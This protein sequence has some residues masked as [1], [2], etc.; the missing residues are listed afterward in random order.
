MFKQI[1]QIY[2][3]FC[4]YSFI[5]KIDAFNAQAQKSQWCFWVLFYDFA[6]NS[7]NVHL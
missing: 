6:S 2:L 5:F 3:L 4:K 1:N 7:F